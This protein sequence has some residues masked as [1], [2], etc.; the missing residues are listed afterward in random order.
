MSL[1]GTSPTEDPDELMRIAREVGRVILSLV[2]EYPQSVFGDDLHVFFRVSS[3][4]DEFVYVDEFLITS[5]TN[6]ATGGYSIDKLRAL[7]L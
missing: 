4:S 6:G 1:K 3:E 7:D 5:P 2:G